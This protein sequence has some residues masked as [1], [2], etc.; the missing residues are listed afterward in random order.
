MDG[1]AILQEAIDG[2]ELRQPDD[3]TMLGVAIWCGLHG[4]TSLA[5]ARRV[6]AGQSAS[7]QELIET[8]VKLVE[9]IQF[10]SA[11]TLSRRRTLARGYGGHIPDNS[12]PHDVPSRVTS[13]VCLREEG[14]R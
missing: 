12:E 4:V 1:A 2:G 9:R 13:S 6:T 10:L 14:P 3:A 11:R 5:I 7:R 8:G